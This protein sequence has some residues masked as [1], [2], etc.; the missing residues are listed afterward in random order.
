MITELQTEMLNDDDDY[1]PTDEQ[2]ELAEQRLA[3][4]IADP[5]CCESAESLIA[6]LESRYL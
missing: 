2:Q 6:Y 1:L 3:E 4:M 5:D